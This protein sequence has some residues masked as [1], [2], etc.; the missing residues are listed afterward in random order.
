MNHFDVRSFLVIVITLLYLALILIF[1]VS[2]RN[3][4]VNSFA[5]PSFTF[6]QLS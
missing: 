4:K 1:D 6:S 3:E 5:P 2:Q